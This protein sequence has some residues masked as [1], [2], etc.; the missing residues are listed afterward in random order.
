MD[1][2]LRPGELYGLHGH[3]VNWLRGQLAVVDVMTRQ[4][5]RQHPKSK[6]SHRG[7]PGPGRHAGGHVAADGWPA[8]RFPDL[9]CAGRRPRD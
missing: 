9:H 5:L 8:A 6:R 2:G 4:G 3:R 7:G 1:V